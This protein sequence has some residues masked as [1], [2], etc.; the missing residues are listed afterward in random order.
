MEADAEMWPS[1]EGTAQKKIKRKGRRSRWYQ[2]VR[3]Q[4]PKVQS[5]IQ[6]KCMPHA[7][8]NETKISFQSWKPFSALLCFSFH[9][10]MQPGFDKTAATAT[11]TQNSLVEANVRLK[12]RFLH[13]SF[14]FLWVLRAARGSCSK[15]SSPLKGSWLVMESQGWKWFE[16]GLDRMVCMIGKSWNLCNLSVS[17]R[18]KTLLL[19]ILC[20]LKFDWVKGLLR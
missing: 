3:C 12:A 16:M 6:L 11:L 19:D 13:F 9:M 18:L 20:L 5:Y 10:K 4:Q 14:G 15:L 7:V 17:K 8:G 1:L 2:V